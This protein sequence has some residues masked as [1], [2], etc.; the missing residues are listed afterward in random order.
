MKK[1]LL[2]LLAFFLFVP[3]LIA[4]DMKDRKNVGGNPKIQN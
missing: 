3:S 2:L 1:Y 4:D